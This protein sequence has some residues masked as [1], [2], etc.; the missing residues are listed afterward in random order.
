MFVLLHS[1]IEVL[2]SKVNKLNTNSCIVK[3]L[4]PK[5]NPQLKRTV[6]PRHNRVNDPLFFHRQV[7]S[8]PF[9]FLFHLSF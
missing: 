9:S 3:K 4:N 6:F 2:S 1:A 8:S 7:F 5:I